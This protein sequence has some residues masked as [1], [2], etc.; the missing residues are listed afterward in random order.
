MAIFIAI[1]AAAALITGL[2]L[3]LPLV[4]DQGRV[5]NRADLDTALFKDQLSEIDRDLER[6]TISHAEAEGAR[7][8]ISRR[9]LTAARAAEAS[10]GPV[11]GP[12]L[13]SG[14]V[15]GLSLMAIP[16]V[17]AAL[18]L[19]NGIPGAPDQPFAERTR[20]GDATFATATGGR[21]SQ[22]EAESAHPASNPSPSGDGE[23]AQLVA[24]LEQRLE[25]NPNDARGLRLLAT[26]YM[27]LERYGEAWRV[28][29]NL[30]MILGPQAEA[31]L[32]AQMA[33]GMVLAAGGYVSPEAESA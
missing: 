26:S 8:E 9:L 30:I 15:A 24:R 28:F 6:G 21:P 12:R 27:R 3:V 23:Y 31:D 1:A 19:A 5:A 18:Y 16:L 32:Y 17:A 13:G 14:L 20:A 25:T 22:A 10:A 2:I 29:D 33:E 7:A 4:L 11:S